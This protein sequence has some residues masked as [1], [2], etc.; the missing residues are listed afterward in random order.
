M[1]LRRSSIQSNPNLGT[2]TEQLVDRSLLG[3]AHIGG[4][5]HTDPAA[6]AND[7]V[8]G[9]AEMAD[10]GPDHEGADEIDGVRGR[11]FRLQ[12]G[13]NVWLPF[14][15]DQEVALAERCRRQRRKVDRAT[16]GGTRLDPGQDP[17]R[18][19]HLS[20]DPAVLIRH[21]PAEDLVDAGSLGIG[22]LV[23]GKL[24]CDLGHRVA[25][26]PVRP[27]GRVERHVVTELD[28]ELSQ[29]PLKRSCNQMIS[30]PR[31]QPI[32]VRHSA[33]LPRTGDG[34]LICVGSR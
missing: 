17:R 4:R 12:F 19:E 26:E 16:K 34:R 24:P 15:I 23:A 29:P 18:H 30:R 20:L 2:K 22:A 5:N 9:L 31:L 10:A 21:D 33:T 32:S 11:Q 25:S 14:G 8:Q 1:Q 27:L 13:A 7:L 6:S 3:R 28:V